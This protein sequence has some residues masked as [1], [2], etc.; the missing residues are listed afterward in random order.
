[1]PNDLLVRHNVTVCG[2]K[3]AAKTLIFVNGLGYRQQFWKGIVPA[4]ADDYRLVLFDHAGSVESNQDDFR[5]RQFRYLNVNGYAADLLEIC[6]A[7]N[8]NGNAILI[9]HSLGAMAGLLASI[10]RPQLFERQV[11]IGASPRY[12]D[13]DG[14]AGGFS[15]EA[16]HATYGA[17]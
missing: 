8:L 15:N 10:E 12:A 6:E 7:L 17:L 5:A 11:L 14:Y 13:A 9:G 16:I 1:M 3:A 4:F 2:N